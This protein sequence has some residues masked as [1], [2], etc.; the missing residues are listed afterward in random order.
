MDGDLRQVGV[1][2]GEDPERLGDSRLA[3]RARDGEHPAG[4]GKFTRTMFAQDLR[5]SVVAAAGESRVLEGAL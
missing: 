3:Q 1:A 2:G 4:L 5:R